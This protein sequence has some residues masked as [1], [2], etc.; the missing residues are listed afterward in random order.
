MNNAMLYAVE[1]QVN[2]LQQTML[3]NFDGASCMLVI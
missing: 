1:I 3:D 2:N